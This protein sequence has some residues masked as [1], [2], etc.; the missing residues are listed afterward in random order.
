MRLSRL[1]ATVAATALFAGSAVAEDLKA[2]TSSPLKIGISL[3]LTGDFADSGKAA[4]RGYTL[5]AAEVNKAGGILGRPVEIKVVND[6]SSPD[7]VV[8]NYQNLITQEKVDIVFGPFSSLLTIPAARIAKRYGY[9]F[10]EPAGGG[11]HV[12]EQHLN[13]LFFVQP[14]QTVKGGDVFADYIL[15]LPPDQRPKTAAYA[16][17]DDPFAAPIADNIKTRFEAAG[18]KTV[19]DQT[20]P[21]ESADLTPII[22]GIAAANPDVL[23]SGTQASDA[24]GQV[25]AM[26]QLKF[27]PK[28]LFMSNGANSPTE[29]PD[30]VGAKNT[31]GVFTSSD[32][33]PGSSA[34]G[35]KDFIN[36]YIAMYGG[37]AD[38]IDNTSAEAY[39]AGMVLA[40]VAKKT[41]TV[42]NASIIETL[43]SGVWP[44]LVGDLSWD[45]DG[46][47]KGEYLLTQWVGGKLTTVFPANQA[48]H[49]PVSPKSNWAQ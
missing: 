38:G 33:Y 11:P 44:T 18:I 6:A 41:G 34:A 42:D 49:A 7:Q 17:L 36:A 1:F 46:A 9:S 14:A 3:S 39:S 24:Y 13:N 5:W 27:N 21:S 32:W 10:I 12:F 22:A 25:K 4:Q 43:H 48:Q 26:I 19:Y 31:E 20:Y 28:W 35:S 47:P 29:F 45:A 37:D 30:K 23:V 8:T 2:G 15:A 16:K 40:Q